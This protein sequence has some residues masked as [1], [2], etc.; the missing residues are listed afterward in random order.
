MEVAM[1]SAENN[2]LIADAARE[3][4]AQTEPGELPLF[5]AISTQYFKRADKILKK[6]SGKEDL[7]GFGIAEAMSVVT[8]AVLVVTTWLVIFLAE[9]AAKSIAEK[10]VSLITKQVKK[11][12]KKFSKEDTKDESALPPLTHEQIAYVRQQAY[13][14]FLQL[15]LS[16][17][18]ANRLA[19]AVVASLIVAPPYKE[20]NDGQHQ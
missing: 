18:R 19:D 20:K 1:T 9:E 2:Q 10:S 14:K 16:E 8:P 11:R 6:Q 4:I 12:F 15:N 13:E 5:Q 3:V 17:T 7:L